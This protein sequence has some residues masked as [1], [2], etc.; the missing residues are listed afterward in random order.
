M[1]HVYSR[2]LARSSYLP[3]LTL[4]IS[5]FEISVARDKLTG[6]VAHYSNT[7]LR[8]FENTLVHDHCEEV[9]DQVCSYGGERQRGIIFSEVFAKCAG[10]NIRQQLIVAVNKQEE[11]ETVATR[12]HLACNRIRI[13]DLVF[14]HSEQLPFL[15]A[16]HRSVCN[17]LSCVEFVVSWIPK[18]TDF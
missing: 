18:C 11:T 7:I 8:E 6:L 3:P 12:N 16:T 14:F 17:D 15:N 1:D 5:P 10:S 9:S 2:R 13:L 4:S